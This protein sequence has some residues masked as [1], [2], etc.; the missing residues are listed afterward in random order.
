MAHVTHEVMP[1]EAVAVRRTGRLARGAEPDAARTAAFDFLTRLAAELSK[2]PLN[3]PCFPDIVPRLRPALADPRGTPDD[4]VRIVG[5]EP[6]LA[7]RLLQTAN[8]AIFNPGGKPLTDLKQ[9]VTRLGTRLV[10]S[11]TM[12]FALQQAKADPLLKR[13]AGPLAALWERSLAVASICQVIARRTR[14]PPE[15]AFLTGLLHGIGEFYM[16]VRAAV[17]SP[18]GIEPDRLAE[19]AAD[20]HPSLG[21]AVLEKWGFEPAIVD[22][23]ANQA[24]GGRRRH[25]EADL[26]DILV[27]AVALAAART[28]GEQRLA[29]LASICSIATLRLGPDDLLALLK[30]TEHALGSLHEA[31][32]C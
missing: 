32:G 1:A 7:A 13:V 2:G 28:E 14:V 21:Q 30:H 27:A 31:L 5:T 3:L 22:A 20:W 25:R 26:T 6:R 23:V 11:V 9:A 29:S 8:S 15:E 19:L 24:D 12:A 4:I 17:D 16:L 10:Q 18:S